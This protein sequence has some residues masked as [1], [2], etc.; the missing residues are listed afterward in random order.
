MTIHY[1]NESIF[2]FVSTFFKNRICQWAK[3]IETTLRMRARFKTH[4]SANADD[5]INVI[6]LNFFCQHVFVIK[7]LIDSI[8]AIV[9]TL[10]FWLRNVINNYLKRIDFS[11]VCEKRVRKI[12]LWFR[13]R[14]R[15]RRWQWRSKRRRNENDWK[16]CLRWYKR[17][18]KR[19][20]VKNA[21]K[22]KNVI[23]EIVDEKSVNFV[24][25]KK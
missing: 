10:S 18:K 6:F 12:V 15:Q 3:I 1:E 13:R 8:R 14:R 22:E 4:R 21:Q 2:E 7:N 17:R 20:S 23:T 16:E 19:D 25:K 24:T 5:D 11:C 9:D